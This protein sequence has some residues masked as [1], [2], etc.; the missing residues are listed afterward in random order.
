MR[1]R[2]R[3]DTGTTRLPGS[4]CA[5]TVCRWT[6]IFPLA[7]LV[8]PAAIPFG[9][10]DEPPASQA[11]TLPEAWAIKEEMLEVASGLVR[12]FPRDST[13][14]GLLGMVHNQQGNASEAVVLWKRCLTLNPY[15][16]DICNCLATV[17]LQRGDH[18]KAI[19]L[20][21]KA[22][23][24]DP[25]METAYNRLGR[26][27]MHVGNS[28]EAIAL[29]QKYVAVNE[30]ADMT[31]YWLGQAYMQ[32]KEYEKAEKHYLAAIALQPNFYSAYYV[33]AKTASRQGDTQA[34]AE[35]RKQFTRYE[36]ENRQ[37]QDDKRQTYGDTQALRQ[38]LARTYTD[39]GEVYQN[40]D[41]M[42]QAEKHWK[43]AA[44]V[45]PANTVCRE[46]LGA[47]Y[48]KQ[49]P[50]QQKALEMFGE[51]V[52]LHP[53]RAS[54]YSHLGIIHARSKQFDDAEKA[55]R[56][57]C[58][59]AP[60]NSKGYSSLVQLYLRDGRQLPDITKLAEK[61]V[62]LKPTAPNYY[63]LSSVYQKNNQPDK[64]Q[65]AIRRALELDLDNPQYGK[66]QKLVQGKP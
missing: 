63:F 61:V 20:W 4:E 47:F 60:E 54:Y 23:R 22:I 57:V 13:A 3:R 18:D 58:E 26:A 10:A 12:Q 52:E 50:S 56:K 8:M 34:A 33:L 51:L 31:H 65:S 64:A 59:L 6:L 7:A 35:Y 49:K 43:K 32:S 27:L 53:E 24:I 66:M 30:K 17:T 1:E 42:W 9:Y 40:H 48:E 16:A 45:D 62:Q 14:V 46:Q 44:T 28:R 39:A 21:R 55:F 29:L 15:R 11:E 37:T 36:A 41:Y 19:A 2:R 5:A 38:E 25:H